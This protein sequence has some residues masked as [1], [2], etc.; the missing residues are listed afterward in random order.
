[1][2]DELIRDT[3]RHSCSQGRYNT[4]K[5]HKGIDVHKAQGHSLQTCRAGH[6]QL[7]TMFKKGSFTDPKPHASRHLE[8]FFSEAFLLSA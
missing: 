8:R 4:R 3:G 2:P 6:L 7:A 1:M 5:R